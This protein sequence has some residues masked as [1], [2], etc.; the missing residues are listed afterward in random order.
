MKFASAAAVVAIVALARG[1]WAAP[2]LPAPPPTPVSPG[3]PSLSVLGPPMLHLS[4]SAT[5]KVEPDELVASLQGVD[6]A[7]TAIAAQRR[8]NELMVKAKAEAAGAAGVKTSFQDYSVDFADQNPTHWTAQQSVE[9]RG[10]GGEQVLDLVGPLQGIGL[11]V[12][13]LG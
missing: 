7:S 1:A 12:A 3:A 4:A 6:I 9:L 13:D 10:A 2:N 8:V 5:V 11:A